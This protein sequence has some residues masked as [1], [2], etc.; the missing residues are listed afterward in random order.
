[1]ATIY[2]NS[3]INFSKTGDLYD[4]IDNNR[5]LKLRNNLF[6]LNL[7][8]K[9]SN[10]KADLK[11]C[12]EDDKLILEFN[13][14]QDTDNKDVLGIFFA[15]PNQINIIINNSYKLYLDDNSN[16]LNSLFNMIRI[17]NVGAC[18]K[19]FNFKKQACEFMKLKSEG[20][21]RV[22]CCPDNI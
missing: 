13:V 11:F 9:V 16:D 15:L 19:Y 18:I 8:S 10:I 12:R 20:W 2:F 4:I 5:H 3:K 1:M 17:F 7:V 22:S 21:K 14:E 6:D